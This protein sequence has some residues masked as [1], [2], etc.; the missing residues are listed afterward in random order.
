MSVAREPADTTAPATI[1][2]LAFA[3][4]SLRASAPS[5]SKGPSR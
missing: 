2:T 5:P 1:R 3:G 4:P